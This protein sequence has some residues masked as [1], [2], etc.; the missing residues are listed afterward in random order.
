VAFDGLD[1]AVAELAVEHALPELKVGAALI[2]QGYG[3]SACFNDARGFWI[4][5][6]ARGALP[7]GPPC[8]CAHR[9]GRAE[10]GERIGAL[11]PLGTPKAF[12][13]GHGGRLFDVRLGKLRKEAARN[14][15]R[16][17]AVNA[18]IGGVDDR[19]PAPCAGDRD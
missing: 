3:G 5:I 14:R 2:A 11:R 10:M 7:A 8:A 1:P 17:L 9:L 19:C 16:P 13:S 15:A 4:D 12:A 18:A 6:A